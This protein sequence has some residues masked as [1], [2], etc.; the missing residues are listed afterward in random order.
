MPNLQKNFQFSECLGF[1]S[2]GEET[3]APEHEHSRVSSAPVCR[4]LMVCLSLAHSFYP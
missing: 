4:Y 3:A 2:R 1:W